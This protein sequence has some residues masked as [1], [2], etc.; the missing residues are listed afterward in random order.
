MHIYT[1]ITRTQPFW[2]DPRWTKSLDLQHVQNNAY[3]FAYDKGVLDNL[4]W[5]LGSP[6]T[7]LA[8]CLL[9]KKHINIDVRNLNFV[10]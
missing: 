8:G 2:E 5:R 10:Q 7:Y 1:L 6:R 4:L 3:P 9:H